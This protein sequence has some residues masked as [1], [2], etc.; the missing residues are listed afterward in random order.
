[1]DD[2]ST[3][4]D[5]DNLRAMNRTSLEGDASNDSAT[6]TANGKVDMTLDLNSGSFP[7]VDD[8]AFVD[9]E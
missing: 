7:Y 1:M 5:A 8:V 9:D 3:S 6:A 2:P 4:E